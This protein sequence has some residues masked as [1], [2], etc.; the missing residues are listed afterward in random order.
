MAAMNEI[1]PDALTPL[2]EA[3][4]EVWGLIQKEKERQ[5]CVCVRRGW[6][7]ARARHTA[8]PARAAAP[9]RSVASRP[10]VGVLCSL[11][12]PP[13]VRRRALPSRRAARLAR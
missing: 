6:R 1:F 10:L 9:A 11:A 12:S 4:P 13:P 3:D 2:K 5:W 7:G 8:A